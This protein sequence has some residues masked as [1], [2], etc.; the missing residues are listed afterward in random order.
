MVSEENS[1]RA[2]LSPMKQTPPS[3]EQ[4][5]KNCKFLVKASTV[6]GTM[7]FHC[8]TKKKA[9]QVAEEYQAFGYWIETT[10]LPPGGTVAVTGSP[11]SSRIP[12]E[13]DPNSSS[14]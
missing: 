6:R 8:K 10:N 5:M 13:Y 4:N 1:E 12:Q 7:I 9:Q 3:Q 11:V 2:E 14:P